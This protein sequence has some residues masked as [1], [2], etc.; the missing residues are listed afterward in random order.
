MRHDYFAENVEK[1]KSREGLD[2][3]MVLTGR[4]GWRPRQVSVLPVACE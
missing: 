1:A 4:E 3:K 2:G